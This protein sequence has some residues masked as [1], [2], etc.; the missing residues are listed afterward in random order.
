[1]A[2]NETLTLAPASGAGIGKLLA[3]QL[4]ADPE[5]LPALVA[6][7]K[8]GLKATRSFWCGKGGDG[9]L[10][11]EPDYRTQLQALALVMAHM[12]GEPIKR[13]IHQHLGN[14][15]VDPLATL[16]DSPA[17]RDALRRLLEKSEWRTSGKQAHK[18]PKVIE[19]AAEAATDES[20]PASGF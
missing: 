11:T 4:L 13:I 18:R 16:Q 9:Y 15:G 1:M 7:A 5:F 14:A 12:E 3:D 8:N 10:E 6:A 2:E 17:A 19:Q 20:G